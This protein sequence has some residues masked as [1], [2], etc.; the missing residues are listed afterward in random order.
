MKVGSLR[1]LRCAPIAFFLVG[2]TLP[3]VATAAHCSENTL[4]EIVV[5]C[6]YKCGSVAHPDVPLASYCAMEDGRCPHV[7]SELPEIPPF[8][9]WCE[10]DS[11][12][13]CDPPPTLLRL[14]LCNQP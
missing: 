2:V 1:A 12:Q 14:E 11:P 3:S 13:T 6:V 4:A 5:A 7:L 8:L 10:R 9:Q